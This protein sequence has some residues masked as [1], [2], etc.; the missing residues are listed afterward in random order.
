[1]MMM[2]TVWT[3]LF[4]HDLVFFLVALFEVFYTVLFI[5]VL[6]PTINFHKHERICHIFGDQGNYSLQR[7]HQ[8]N[9]KIKPHVHIVSRTSYH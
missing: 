3:H 4:I 8:N 2:M 1:M 7:F 6:I 5:T 9:L